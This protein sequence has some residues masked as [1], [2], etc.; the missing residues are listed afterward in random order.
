MCAGGG[1]RAEK[2]AVPLPPPATKHACHAMTPPIGFPP[3]PPVHSSR[4]HTC[5]GSRCHTCYGSRCHTCHGSPH[6]S[7]LPHPSPSH[8]YV[9]HIPMS[10]TY[11]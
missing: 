5:H 6:Q 3:P 1:A 9:S 7:P 4:C 8:I 11:L 10:H 2:R